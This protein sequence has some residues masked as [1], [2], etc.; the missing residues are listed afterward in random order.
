[1]AS[2]RQ[3]QRFELDLSGAQKTTED[4]Y[5]YLI[6]GGRKPKV[7]DL[8]YCRNVSVGACSLV[9]EDQKFAI[10]QD[11]C[12]VRSEGE[13]SR[14]LCYFLRSAAV[15]YQLNALLIGSTFNRIN[16]ADI[17]N[18]V[19]IRPPRDEQEVI[20]KYLDLKTKVI[21]VAIESARKEIGLVREYRARL[22]A[23]V[24]T[25]RLDVRAAAASIPDEDCGP[26]EMRLADE[27][28]E[29]AA[30]ADLGMDELIGEVAE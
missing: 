10:G 9:S 24:V 14:F 5:K 2:V 16:V 25:G 4:G 20:V 21:D 6:S 26:G 19:V 11:V 18:L 3:A 28:F 13:N 27:I 12:L 23:D 17:K 1:M 30:E 15:R 22:V 7:G 8:I 29:E